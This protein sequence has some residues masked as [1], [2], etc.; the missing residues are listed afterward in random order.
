MI[1]NIDDLERWL[2]RILGIGEIPF[3]GLYTKFLN[4]K[5]RETYKNKLIN[6][7]YPL[8][9]YI[10]YLESWPAVSLIYLTLHVCEGF[11]QHGT[12]EVYP[13]IHSA[14]NLNSLTTPQKEN[15]WKAYRR[16]CLKLGL[17]VSTRHSGSN[18]MVEEYLRQ[19]GVPISYVNDLTGKMLRYAN[20]AGIPDD[21]DPAA[22]RRWQDGLATRLLPPFSK[23]AQRGIAT[24]DT[25]FYVRL[26]LRLLEKPADKDKAMSD[27]EVKMSDEIQAHKSKV[28]DVLR[29]KGKSLGIPQLLWRD[30][31]LGVELPPGD[32]FS[33][34]I[35]VGDNKTDYLGQ[36]ESRFVPIDEALP[37]SVEVSD[38]SGRRIT[39][40]TPLW[41]D[42]R[43]NRLLVFAASGAFIRAGKL[44]SGEILSLE[45]GEYQLLLRF[46]PD[47]MEEN[48][49]S[50]RR[51][52]SLYGMPLL[53]EPAEKL[54]LRRGPALLT[55]QADAKPLMMWE[56]QNI[57]G[58]R[59][60]ELYCGTDLNL[61]VMLPNEFLSEGSHYYIRLSSSLEENPITIRITDELSGVVSISDQIKSASWKPGVT[62]ILAELC[63]I[64]MQRPLLRSSVITWI[65]LNNAESRSRFNYTAYPSNVLLDECDN[66][67]ENRDKSFFSYRNEDNRFFRMVFDLGNEKRFIF[68]SSVP[69]IFLQLREYSETSVTEKLLKKGGT[70]TVAWNSR[71]EIE[72]YSTSNGILRFGKF[73]KRIDFNNC[74]SKRLP[75]S[76]LVEYLGP[77]ADTLEFVDATT[78]YSEDLLHIVSP[79]EILKFSISRKNNQYHI[80]FALTQEVTE[81]SLH[82][83][84]LFSGR[85]E[86]LVMRC[87]SSFERL[88]SGIN[89][90]L[91]CES[92]LK[93]DIRI[94]LDTWPDGVWVLDLEAKINGRWGHFSNSRGDRYSS[95]FIVIDGVVTTNVLTSLSTLDSLDPDAR[96]DILKRAHQKVLLCYAKESWDQLKWIETLWQELLI[97]FE[98]RYEYAAA[99]IALSEQPTP[100]EFSCTWI[101]IFSPTV[102]NPG[103]YALSA[104]RYN[105]KTPGNASLL[106][107]TLAVMARMDKGLLR[108]LSIN[109]MNQIFAVGYANI[110]QMM[111]GMEPQN[112]S[113]KNYRDAMKGHDLSERMKLL[114]ED[115][116]TPGEG[117]YLGSLHYRFSLASLQQRYHE[118]MAG[119][120]LRRPK[121]L[122]ICRTMRNYHIQG[123]PSVLDGSLNHIGYICGVDADELTEEQETISEICLFLSHFAKVCRWEARN[124][125][126]LNTFISKVKQAIEHETLYEP[127]LG[128]ILHIGKDIFSFYLMLWEA[129]MI[130]EYDA[131]ERMP[132]V[133]K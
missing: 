2:Q 68:T 77:D 64:D 39:P 67:L 51:E 6:S 21:D 43:D 24:D 58:V 85:T 61:K 123:I 14:L 50:I 4:N 88:D 93:H 109:V 48:V 11:G 99:I 82:A 28:K 59:G 87:N 73:S 100:E 130:S 29:K 10:V 38:S 126:A 33:W 125:G 96:F 20:I 111:Q 8:D 36:I 32:G 132:D 9:Q 71:S 80:L 18:Y 94:S 3:L 105:R 37:V 131:I 45:P 101:P 27:F 106:L 22:I 42:T 114:S 75:L 7:R 70:V 86:T 53:L 104:D 63:R 60:N 35:T 97:Y 89:G 103:L 41:E 129:I 108:L 121:A 128:F 133:R 49:E 65:G 83:T 69:G 26:F 72:I 112:F 118:T 98:K 25:G 5:V 76:G 17:S 113:M 78:G 23:V 122:F 1:M 74:G 84:D 30:N 13:F 66:L 19:S 46:V 119:N 81:V 124:Q 115:D 127:V 91:T 40:V 15:L 117:D 34:G 110:H 90:W 52:P 56:G 16:A 54:V 47:E 31:R 55:I 102:R 107:K 120:D 12:F 57:R 79:H 44:N 62:R 95:G 92:D 116:W